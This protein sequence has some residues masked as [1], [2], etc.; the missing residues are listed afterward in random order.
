MISPAMDFF[1]DD[2]WNKYLSEKDFSAEMPKMYLYSG[3]NDRL[4][5]AAR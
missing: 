1:E 2:A 3:N 4:S 5:A